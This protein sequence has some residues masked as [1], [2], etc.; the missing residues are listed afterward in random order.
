MAD[1]EAAGRAGEAAVGDQRDLAAHALTVE[2]PGGR[3]HFSHARPAAW[4]LIADDEDFALFV[5]LVLDRL[6]A[7]LFAVEAARR[8][9]ELEFGQAGD[10]HDRALGREVALE[11]D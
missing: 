11:A 3:E 2:H 4:A 1:A 5:F 7:R 8:A 6:E 9:G 10:L